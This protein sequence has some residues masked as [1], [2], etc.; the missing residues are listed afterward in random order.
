M[1]NWHGMRF[2]SVSIIPCHPLPCSYAWWWHGIIDTEL[3]FS[4]KNH[5]FLSTQIIRLKESRYEKFLTCTFREDFGRCSCRDDPFFWKLYPG[6]RV[7]GFLL[8]LLSSEFWK[9][10]CKKTFFLNNKGFVQRMKLLVHYLYWIMVKFFW[11]FVAD[12]QRIPFFY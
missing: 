9:S 12:I 4:E 3:A 2:N 11:K 6:V 5:R 1:T 10:I 7:E 8:I